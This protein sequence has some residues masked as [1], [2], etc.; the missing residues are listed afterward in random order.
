MM[1]EAAPASSFE[2]GQGEFAFQFLAVVAAPSII[3]IAVT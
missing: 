1:M 2:M 3:A